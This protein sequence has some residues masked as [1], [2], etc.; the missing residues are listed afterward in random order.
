M[1]LHIPHSSTNTLGRKIEQFDINYLTDWYTDDLFWHESA[2]RLVFPYSRFICDVERFPDEQEPMFKYG[3]GI[4]YTRGTRENDIEVTDKEEMMELYR[5]HHR[6]FNVMTNQSL[7]YFPHVII[8]DCHSFP[9]NEGDPDICIG[10]N[11]NT[12]K[13]LIDAV[14]AFIQKSDYGYAI[15]RPYSGSIF[16][17][18]HTDNPNVDSI[19]I[20]VNKKLYLNDDLSKSENYMQIKLFIY[21]ILDVI[22]D[23]ENSQRNY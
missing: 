10:T 22:S 15:N 6:K 8:V 23:V 2:D 12:S 21:G 9:S 3:Q 7:A 20:E 18:R 5:E 14:E 13:T 4:C 17:S 1:I 11:P 16:P 19:M